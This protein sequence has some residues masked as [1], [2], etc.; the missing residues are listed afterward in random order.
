MQVLFCTCAANKTITH[1]FSQFLEQTRNISFELQK[2]WPSGDMCKAIKT[3]KKGFY[4]DLFLLD[5]GMASNTF[6]SRHVLE[7]RQHLSNLQI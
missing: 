7:F 3:A 1:N 5:F 6:F 2:S 4:K